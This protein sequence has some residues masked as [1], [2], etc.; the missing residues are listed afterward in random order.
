[1]A[2]VAA[3]VLSAPISTGENWPVTLERA[4]EE[5]AE[6]AGWILIATGLT[7]ITLE[8]FLASPHVDVAGSGGDR[9][10]AR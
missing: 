1:M 2:A 5:A 7:A 9:H 6:L 4:F 3:E 10:P 8:G